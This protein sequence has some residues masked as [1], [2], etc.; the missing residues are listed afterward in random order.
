MRTLKDIIEEQQGAREP[1]D[2]VADRL[3]AELIRLAEENCVLRDRLDTCRRLAAA[4]DATDD[5]AIDAF[6][7]DETT[8]KA[9][10]AAHR[11]YFEALFG[12]LSNRP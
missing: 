11:S 10:L 7:I 1:A 4:G 12:R 9:R 3:M 8:L 5:A 2:E 6:E